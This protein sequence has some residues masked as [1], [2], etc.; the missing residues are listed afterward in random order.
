MN[1]DKRDL[2]FNAW[3]RGKESEHA[4]DSEIVFAQVRRKG[5]DGEFDWVQ[6]NL[7]VKVQMRN[8]LPNFVWP[9]M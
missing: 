7:P 5:E 2:G 1:E 9:P 6:D 4:Y 3:H 8:M